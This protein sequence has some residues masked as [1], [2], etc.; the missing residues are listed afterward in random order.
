M[1]E[2]ELRTED[3]VTAVLSEEVKH[4]A[5]DTM[6]FWAEDLHSGLGSG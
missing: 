6:Y 1:P 4:E 3:V 5:P 2:E